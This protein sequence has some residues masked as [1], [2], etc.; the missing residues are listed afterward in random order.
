MELAVE[1]LRRHGHD[2]KPLTGLS[3]YKYRG[4][5]ETKKVVKKTD[6]EKKT[7]SKE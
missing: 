3:K 6:G 4:P 7:A 2:V 1:M 5:A